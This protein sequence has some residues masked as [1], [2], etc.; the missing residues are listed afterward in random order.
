MILDVL[1]SVAL[2]GAMVFGTAGQASAATPGEFVSGV[3][4]L[5]SHFLLA[6][7]ASQPISL[8]RIRQAPVQGFFVCL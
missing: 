2:F 6:V 1:A 8:L 4:C 5:A 7:S 3:D